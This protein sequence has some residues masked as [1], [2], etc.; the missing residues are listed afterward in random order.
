MEKGILSVAGLRSDIKAIER[1]ASLFVPTNFAGRSEAI[2]FL[3]FHIIDRISGLLQHG[4]SQGES[5]SSS[6]GDSPSGS[7]GGSAGALE[8]LRERAERI[9]GELEKIDSSLMER[10]R[11]E[12]A[13]G[14][15]AGASFGEMIRR[16]CGERETHG[17]DETG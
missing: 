2:D 3:D 4:G 16:L 11:G 6:Q 13:T 8:L 12:I 10:V 5:P 14:I 15:S 7:Q 17:H 1:E 9:K